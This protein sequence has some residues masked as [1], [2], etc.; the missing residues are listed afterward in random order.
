MTIQ[1]KHIW[2]FCFSIF[3]VCGTLLSTAQIK[4]SS[5]A[6][7][8]TKDSTISKSDSLLA[9][10]KKKRFMVQHLYL[11]IDPSKLVFNFFDSTKTRIEGHFD[12][13]LNKN[14]IVNTTF[15]YV[16]AQ[17]NNNKLVMSSNS[18]G[19]TVDVC[20]S[21]FPKMGN[22]DLDFAF[23]GIGYGFSLN[24]ISNI[25][26]SFSDLYGTY[27]GTVPASTK[28]LHW[29]QLSAGFMM[30]LK[31]KIHA[32]WRINGRALLNQSALL[33]VAPLYSAPFGAGDK[34]TVF[35]YNLMISY[36][37]Y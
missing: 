21:L 10:P 29:V 11:G 37:L 17:L 20:R 36:R 2:Q 13:H 33:N 7:P 31:P 26:Y 6:I 9:L 5:K 32:G 3:V 4:D 24:R 28:G 34:S 16:N 8:L 12:V 19:A 15:G 35:G 30:Q 1:V 22:F 18:A 14:I 27:T 25:S 23:V